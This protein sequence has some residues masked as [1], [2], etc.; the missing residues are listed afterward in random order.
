MRLERTI[1]TVYRTPW[2][3]TAEAYDAVQ[4]L[5][6]SKLA[7]SN[8]PFEP[9]EAAPI[10]VKQGKVAVLN[11]S[12]I[13]LPKCSTLE[14]VCGAVSCEDIRKAIKTVSQDPAIESVIF[15][16]DSPGGV[17]TGIAETGKAIA[18][19]SKL[20]HT[21]SYS[22]SEM[23]SAAYWLA[24]QT[25]EIFASESATV[26]SIGVY[27]AI[28]TIAEQLKNEGV[29]AEI[30]QRGA[31]KTLGMAY[32][33]MTDDERAFLQAGVDKSYNEFTGTVSAARPAIPASA[34]E[35]QCFDGEEALAVHLVDA[36]ENDLGDLVAFINA[37]AFDKAA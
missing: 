33:D 10:L 34:M 21:A 25:S 7:A 11:I 16:F 12:G 37:R 22:M 24:S 29:K 27:L 5:I 19:L 8:L 1:R 4:D 17:V 26:G 15:N 20:K 28:L 2:G 14:K 9:E 35:G 23:C 31:F 13:L 36:I 32:R 6:N 18:A 3:I 30:F